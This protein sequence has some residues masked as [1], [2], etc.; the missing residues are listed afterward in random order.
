MTPP[1][2][3][4]RQRGP[5]WQTAS[6]QSSS[7]WQAAKSSNSSSSSSSNS[8]SECVKSVFTESPNVLPPSIHA[9]DYRREANTK[10]WACNLF[11]I[12]ALNTK[13]SDTLD[14]CLS[15]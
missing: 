3:A 14:T 12:L 7:G 5:G 13:V 1:Q 8:D 4:S 9:H 15:R 10:W 11:A 2:S 6:Q